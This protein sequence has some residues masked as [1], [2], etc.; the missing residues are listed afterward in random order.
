MQFKE[1]INEDAIKIGGKTKAPDYAFRIGGQRI[2]FVEAKRPS[3]KLKD[4]SPAMG[5]DFGDGG[6]CGREKSQNEIIR[7]I[8]QIL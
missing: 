8:W 2:F 1:V 4:N 3:I 7:G 5:R 6:H